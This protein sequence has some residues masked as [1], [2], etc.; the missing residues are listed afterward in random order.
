M[1]DRPFDILEKVGK[2]DYRLSVPLYMN[3]YSSMNVENLKLFKSSML[4]EENN[5]KALPSLKDLTLDAQ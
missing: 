4:D 3:I 5:E 1:R 2:N